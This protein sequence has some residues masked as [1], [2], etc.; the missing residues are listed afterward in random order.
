MPRETL[1]QSSNQAR[2]FLP[3]WSVA[4]RD[5]KGSDLDEKG[6]DLM[7]ETCPPQGEIR[8]MPDVQDRGRT[9]RRISTIKREVRL[10]HCQVDCRA[11]RSCR[12]FG[13]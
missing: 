11:A 3:L 5:E 6:S 4:S 1:V 9:L 7:S 2:N 13:R 10:G 12:S 8:L